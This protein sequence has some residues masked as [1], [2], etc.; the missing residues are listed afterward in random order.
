MEDG[1]R[2]HYFVKLKDSEMSD[3]FMALSLENALVKVWKKGQ[4]EEQ[5]EDYS[6]KGFDPQ[7][8]YLALR[9]EKTFLGFIVSRRT[10][11]NLF[12]RLGGSDLLTFTTGTLVWKQGEHRLYL[13]EAAFRCQKRTNYRLVA[14]SHNKVSFLIGDEEFEVFDLSASG[15]GIVV[16]KSRG[17]E[18]DKERR[19]NDCTVFLNDQ[20]YCIPV[21]EIVSIWEERTALFKVTGNLEIGIKFMDLSIADEEKFSKEIHTLAREAEVRKTLLKRAKAEG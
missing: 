4:R 9:P 2:K 5:A 14:D 6:I 13:K 16:P 1:N 12:F 10:R 7:K 17:G 15:V 19:F 3:T 18:F 21:V 8:M 11:A 20:S